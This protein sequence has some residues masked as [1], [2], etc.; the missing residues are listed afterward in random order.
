LCMKCYTKYWSERLSA[1]SEKYGETEAVK[2][3][4]ATV[5][6]YNKYANM[7]QRGELDP[8]KLTRWTER[9]KELQQIP[10][11]QWEKEMQDL[12]GMINI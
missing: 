4:R 1:T 10:Q 8:E 6:D 11:L 7:D 12:N 3:M 9:I 2:L 5:L